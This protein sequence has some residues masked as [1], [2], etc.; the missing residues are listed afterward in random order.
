MASAAGASRF[1]LPTV[2]YELGISG[3]G[4]AISQV[5]TMPPFTLVFVILLTLAFSIHHGH[6]SPWV[7]GL[8]V[9]AV[10]IVCYIL[11]I[12]VRHPIAKYI[13]VTIATAASQSFFPIIWLGMSE[14]WHSSLNMWSGS[15]LTMQSKNASA[16]RGAQH[17]PAWLLESQM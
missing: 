12:I 10:Q 14:A 11:L 17:L 7:A 6:L 13:F 8:G 2:I 15:E 9:E 4:T 1:V 16:L 3:T 5:M